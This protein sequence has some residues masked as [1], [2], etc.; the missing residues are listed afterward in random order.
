MRVGGQP[1]AAQAC[2]GRQ[3]QKERGGARC[4]GLCTE[5]GYPGKQG[6]AVAWC[7][8]VC[9]R[10]DGEH[11]GHPSCL[12]IRAAQHSTAWRRRAN[13]QLQPRAHVR[14]LLAACVACWLRV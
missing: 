7:M 1:P 8:Q 3:A 10:V 4:C 5:A 12:A 2:L 13:A 14:S 11:G 6:E 9:G